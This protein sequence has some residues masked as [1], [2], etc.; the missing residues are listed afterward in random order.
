MRVMVIVILAR[1][2]IEERIILV[3]VPTVMKHYSQFLED[4]KVSKMDDW[5]CISGSKKSKPSST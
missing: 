3:Q 2:L 4:I 5:A 1:R